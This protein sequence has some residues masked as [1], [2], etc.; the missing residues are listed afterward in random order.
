MNIWD[1]FI[2]TVTG[3][4]SESGFAQF[5]VGDGYKNLI[6]IAVACGLGL[7]ILEAA[8]CLERG[9]PVESVIE[10]LD[11]LR[12]AGVSVRRIVKAANGNIT[13]DSFTVDK[14]IARHPKDRKKMAIV[15][16]GRDAIT[17]VKVM[18]R[19]GQVIE[20]GTIEKP[21]KLEGRNMLMFIAPAHNK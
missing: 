3:I 14:P 4:L 16:G 18:E 12:T 8:E 9:M 7:L 10:R 21:A 1:S 19:F 17:H 15:Y 20:G 11:K 2:Q 13:E 6:M 5:F